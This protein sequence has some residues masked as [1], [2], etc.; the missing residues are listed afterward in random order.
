MNT[1]C[2]GCGAEIEPKV[3]WDAY[4]AKCQEELAAP[5]P[6]DWVAKPERGPT[7]KMGPMTLAEAIHICFDRNFSGNFN[8]ASHFV[9]TG[10][11][12]IIVFLIGFAPIAIGLSVLVLFGLW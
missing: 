3:F 5:E 2:N 12:M 8:E 9:G 6:P 1:E 7:K 4:C 11:G 10:F